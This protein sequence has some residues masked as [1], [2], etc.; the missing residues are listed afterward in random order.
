MDKWIKTMAPGRGT[1]EMKQ[2]RVYEPPGQYLTAVANSGMH[3]LHLQVR[4]GGGKV[5]AL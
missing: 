5:V 2:N 4:L 1:T 3:S